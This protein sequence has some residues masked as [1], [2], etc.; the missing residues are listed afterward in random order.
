MTTLEELGVDVIG[1]VELPEKGWQM[2]ARRMIE[3]RRKQITAAFRRAKAEHHEEALIAELK[4][5]A[6][7][8]SYLRACESAPTHSYEAAD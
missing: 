7:L 5:M 1:Q 6:D 2:V 8:E 3:N 4:R